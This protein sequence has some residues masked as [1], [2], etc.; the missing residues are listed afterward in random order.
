MAS[1][2]SFAPESS[3][4]RRRSSEEKPAFRQH[5]NPSAVSP[6]TVVVEKF[7]PPL[8]ATRASQKPHDTSIASSS[9]STSCGSGD[10]PVRNSISNS[11]TTVA[12]QPLPDDATASPDQWRHVLERTF[13]HRTQEVAAVVKG[14]QDK[15]DHPETTS[16]IL[17]TGPL[18]MGKTRLVQ[19]ALS[20]RVRARG[21]YCIRGRHDWSGRPIPYCGL[22]SAFDDYV[23]QVVERGPEAIDAVRFAVSRAVGDECSVLVRIFP[24]L[25]RIVGNREDDIKEAKSEDTLQRFVFVFFLFINAIASL[26]HPLVLLLDDMHWADACFVDLISLFVMKRIGG[27]VI[28]CTYD[29]SYRDCYFAQRL[30]EV[31]TDGCVRVVPIPLAPLDTGEVTHVLGNALQLSR[32]DMVEDLASIVSRQTS[33]NMFYIIEFLQWMQDSDLLVF[34]RKNMTWQWDASEIERVLMERGHGGDFLKEKLEELPTEML[35]VLKVAASFGSQLD[36]AQIE[37]VLD[38]P[39]DSIL[40]Q[41]K[42][43]HILLVDERTGVY[44][45]GHDGI[46]KAVY[47]LIPV[48]GR[49]LFHLEA[50]RRLWRRLKEAELEQHLFVLL[51]QMIMGKRLITR[52]KERYAIASLCL[53]AGKK[54]AKL[55][56]FRL[57]TVYLNFGIGLLGDRGWRDEYD[58]TLAMYNAAA[59]MNMCTGHFDAMEP[60]LESVLKHS[61]SSCD[62]I[63]AE[64]TKIYALGMADRQDDALDLGLAVLAGLGVKLPWSK[65]KYSM[66]S[67][68]K[69]VHRL[70]RGKSN[71]QLMRL[72]YIGDQDI[73]ACL[74][75]LSVVSVLSLIGALGHVVCLFLSHTSLNADVY[76]C[77][78]DSTTPGSVHRIENDETDSHSWSQFAG[79]GSV[80]RIRNR[81]HECIAR[82][83]HGVSLWRTCDGAQRQVECK[84]VPTS[85]IRCILWLHPSLEATAS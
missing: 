17:V 54:A 5:M 85:D 79:P 47:K 10:S 84:G 44:E 35:D 69:A 30:K 52:E 48:D 83:R 36:Q 72:P 26:E 59:E 18:G 11:S 6:P 8:K 51:S 29:E 31:N 25:R 23:A 53:H 24:S 68:L 67:E 34:D 32:L 38:F 45:F 12:S 77:Y 61:R 9:S 76:A 2:S 28:V 39:I 58:L 50:G 19:H 66:K 80:F 75:I 40:S 22:V 81:M 82:C 49:E 65:C 56:T 62:R 15:L 3:A 27:L 21:G 43:I 37:Y 13:F 33:G 16:F 78:S 73:L 74:K 41:A 20:D 70:L 71:E 55:S 57:A 42:A 4:A 7:P 64:S 60:L 46:Q 1:S 14:F 63:Q